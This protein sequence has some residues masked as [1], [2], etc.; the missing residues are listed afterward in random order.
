ML[1][2][3]IDLMEEKRIFKEFIE[4]AV[5]ERDTHPIGYQGIPNIGTISCEKKSIE[6]PKLRQGIPR[7]I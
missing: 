6:G 5:K 7:K 2:A 4:Q 3:I 1:R